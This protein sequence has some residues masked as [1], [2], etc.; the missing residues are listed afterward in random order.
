MDDNE[1]ADGI[2]I[3][4]LHEHGEMTETEGDRTDSIG[5]DTLLSMTRREMLAGTAG[6][7]LGLGVLG[8]STGRTRAETAAQA[9]TTTNVSA[10]HLHLGLKDTDDGIHLQSL[11]DE[12]GG[13]IKFAWD[14]DNLYVSARVEDDDH[15]QTQ[16]GGTTWKEDVLQVGVAGDE[17]DQVGK[18]DE[19][20]IAPD[21][22]TGERFTTTHHLDREVTFEGSTAWAWEITPRNSREGRR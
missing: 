13:S 9:G 6:V 8:I 15:I 12:L 19:L 7:G 21:G 17:P 4:Q 14:A 11:Y 20:D 3:E 2:E 1:H 10:G 5:S 18:W 22:P 16:D